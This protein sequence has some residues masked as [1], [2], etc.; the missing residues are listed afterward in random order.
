MA[1]KIVTYLIARASPV[2]MERIG[3][4][5][6]GGPGTLPGLFASILVRASWLEECVAANELLIQTNDGRVALA[7]SVAART[8]TG[9]AGILYSIVSRHGEPIR[10][11]DLCDKAG[12]FGLRETRT[13]TL[14]H[15]RR[16]ACLFML[17]RGSSAWWDGT[18][19]RI[20]LNTKPR[21]RSAREYDQGTRLVGRIEGSLGADIQVRRSIHE[22]GLG[23]P[24]PFS[25]ARV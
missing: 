18:R 23:L 3:S 17:S 7:P 20:L 1:R 8:P 16:A 13:G 15:S 21:A 14:I 19:T 4:R 12:A 25:L 6:I 5:D 10:M 9:T 2:L 22:Q 24:W 11:Q